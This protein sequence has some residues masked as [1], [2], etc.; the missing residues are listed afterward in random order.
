MG[1]QILVV[2]DDAEIAQLIQQLL[3][4]EG[5]VCYYCAE[6]E[7]AMATFDKQVLDLIVLDRSLPGEMDGLEFCTYIRQ[8]P[9]H[10]NPYI[11][12]ISEKGEEIDV[13]VGLSTGADDYIVKPFGSAELVARVRALLRRRLR[14]TKQEETYRTAHFTLD[15]EQHTVR[16]QLEGR[17]PEEITLATLDFRLLTVFLSKPGKAWTRNQLIENLWGDNFFGDDRVVDTQV[18]RLRKKIEPNPSK[19]IFIKT[20]TGV[21]YKFEDTP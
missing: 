1:K 11:L 17:L 2:E 12:M 4:Q 7:Q 3:E 19:P 6:S 5:F 10:P 21:G 16:R 14:E 8:H 15:I 13:V 20:V 18:A 9:T